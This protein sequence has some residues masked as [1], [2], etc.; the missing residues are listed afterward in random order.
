MGLLPPNVFVGGINDSNDG[1]TIVVKP[2]KYTGPGNRDI[3]F[4]GKT[5]TVR[6]ANPKDPNVLAATIIDCNGTNT[7]EHGVTRFHVNGAKYVLEIAK[8][9][10]ASRAYLKG[11]SP[12]CDRKGVT[13]EVLKCGGVKVIRVP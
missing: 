6:S 3:D 12:S 5:I 1:D 10:G 7:E 9:V 13:G 4:K 8:I 11:G 2:G